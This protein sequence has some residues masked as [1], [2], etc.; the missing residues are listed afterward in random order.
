MLLHC[1]DAAYIIQLA[2]HLGECV[3]CLQLFI[4]TE[5]NFQLFAKLEEERVIKWVYKILNKEENILWS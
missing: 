3:S 1:M 4:V 5:M 2:P